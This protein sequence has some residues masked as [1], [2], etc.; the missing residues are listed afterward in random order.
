MC[1]RRDLEDLVEEAAKK[2]NKGCC[3]KEGLLHKWEYLWQYD[4]KFQEVLTEELADVRKAYLPGLST[5]DPRVMLDF[6]VQ[7]THTPKEDEE[8]ELDHSKNY[9]VDPV[10]LYNLKCADR[11]PIYSSPPSLAGRVAAA[12]A[13]ARVR[14]AAAAT[15]TPAAV[16][17]R[18]QR[19]VDGSIVAAHRHRARSRAGSSWATRRATLWI[20][21]IAITSPPSAA[22][23]TL[24]PVNC[25]ARAK[26]ARSARE[27]TES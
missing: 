11:R 23:G 25:R 22:A 26:V 17:T 2:Q 7:P 14:K 4:E 21:L 27:L 24:R 13:A 1:C 9:R 6:T 16:M 20:P 15:L 8:D 3:G 12:A 19:A 18:G 5:D 10:L